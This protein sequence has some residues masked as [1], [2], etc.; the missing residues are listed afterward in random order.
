MATRTFACPKFL[1]AIFALVVAKDFANIQLG[2]ETYRVEGQKN[3][4]EAGAGGS[5]AGVPA[6]AGQVSVGNGQGGAAEPDPC[7]L[8]KPYPELLS[9]VQI[10]ELWKMRMGSYFRKTEQMLDCLREYVDE[11]KNRCTQLKYTASIRMAFHACTCICHGWRRPRATKRRHSCSQR[12]A[13]CWP[14]Q[15]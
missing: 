12:R 13:G 11:L 1:R 5:E 2:C 15:L 6:A 7:G 14:W 4:S 9:D 10:D 3:P 8:A